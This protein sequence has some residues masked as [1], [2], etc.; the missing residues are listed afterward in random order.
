[1]LANIFPKTICHVPI[2][3]NFHEIISM[4]GPVKPCDAI[5]EFLIY[6]EASY[7]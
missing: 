4:T 1:M 2:S 3:M 7:H 6:I 5:S